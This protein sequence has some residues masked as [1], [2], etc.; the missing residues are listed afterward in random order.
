MPAP[1]SALHSTANPL[2][3]SRRPEPLFIKGLYGDPKPSPVAP[4]GS[5]WW[6][7]LASSTAPTVGPSR[8]TLARDVRMRS[9]PGG[10]IPGCVTLRLRRP[11]VGVPALLAP[12]LAQSDTIGTMTRGDR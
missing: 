6:L 7:M 3:Q 10:N 11:A 8:S 2:N 4:G 1:P 5:T 9:S 12:P